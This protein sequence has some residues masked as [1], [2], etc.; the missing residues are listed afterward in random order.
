MIKSQKLQ[1]MRA[2]ILVRQKTR[3]LVLCS[4]QLPTRKKLILGRTVLPFLQL[5]HSALCS[6]SRAHGMSMTRS[7]KLLLA[8]ISTEFH[9]TL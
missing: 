3:W 9:L 5:S 7:P 4:H 6:T 1:P 8:N 2:W